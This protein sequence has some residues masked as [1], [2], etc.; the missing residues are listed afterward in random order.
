MRVPQS[1]APDLIVEA[2]SLCDRQCAG[3]YAPNLVSKESP[4]NLFLTAPEL[5][6]NP[7]RLRSSLSFLCARI[8]NEIPLLSIRGG[9]P[10]LHPELVT[11]L[12][13]CSLFAEQVVLETH[14]R[15]VL[16]NSEASSALLLGCLETS[17]SIKISFDK[18]HALSAEN[19]WRVVTRLAEVGV[20]Y[21]IAITEP[22]E[23]DFATVRGKCPEISDEKFIF[24]KKV[25][26][27]A[28][29]MRPALGVIH[30]NGSHSSQLQTKESFF[31]KQ[32]QAS[33]RSL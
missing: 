25:K 9:E 1:F 21:R 6:L 19:L 22:T 11:I 15:W 14:A 30:T 5:F 18:M 29:L 8:G 4:T 12:E 27:A 23:E 16:E 3:C 31:M 33:G 28:E 17:T 7:D 26:T 24:Q 2:T 13:T 32:P 20:R 10:S